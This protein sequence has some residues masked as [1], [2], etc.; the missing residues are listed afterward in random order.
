[1]PLSGRLIRNHSSHFLEGKTEIKAV[2]RLTRDKDQMRPRWHQWHR[3][4]APDPDQTPPCKSLWKQS[5]AIGVHLVF[6]TCLASSPSRSNYSCLFRQHSIHSQRI[7][8]WEISALWQIPRVLRLCPPGRRV[9]GKKSPTFSGK[10][11]DPRDLPH[12]HAPPNHKSSPSSMG[13]SERND[14]FSEVV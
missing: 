6:H 13:G 5:P 10:K 9:A 11:E 8:S 3:F 1:M 4:G 7:F 14:S 2:K 12:S